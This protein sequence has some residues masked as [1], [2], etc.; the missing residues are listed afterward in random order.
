MRKYITLIISC[1]TI[2]VGRAQTVDQI[3]SNSIHA[4]GGKEKIDSMHSVLF[5]TTVHAM[6]ADAPSTITI[7]NGK[8]IRFESDI[9]GDK[10]IQVFN[11]KSGWIVNPMASNTSPA[12]MDEN[13]YLAGKDQIEIGGPLYNYKEKGSVALLKGMDDSA[14]IVKITDVNQ[15][16]TTFYIDKKTYLIS[17]TIKSD[18][19]MGS[20]I[21]ITKYYYDYQEAQNGF[22]YPG[23]EVDDYGKKFSIITIFKSI[24][25]NPVVPENIFDTP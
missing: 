21:E 25:I 2:I 19:M 4:I 8:G 13:Q 15:I 17:K 7:V 6:G 20:K 3:I 18:F 14:Y 1:C 11:D 9:Q 10:M 23:R 24:Q 16:S 22:S 12:N 5:I